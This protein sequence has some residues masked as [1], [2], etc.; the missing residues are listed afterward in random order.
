VI[1]GFP[2]HNAGVREGD[3]LAKFDGYELDNF[4]EAIVEWSAA[5]CTRVVVSH[6]TSHTHTHAQRAPLDSLIGLLTQD[7]TPEI[8][9]LREGKPTTVKLCLAD[10][11]VG[12]GDACVA[13]VMSL[14]FEGTWVPFAAVCAR[15]SPAVRRE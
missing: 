15:V 1:K 2:M 5:V 11:K 6:L 12:Q 7:S 10:P 8:T 3:V 4:G 14:V 9:Y 13:R